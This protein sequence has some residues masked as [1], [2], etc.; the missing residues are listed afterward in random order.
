MVATTVLVII[1]V[2]VLLVSAYFDRHHLD[3]EGQRL[4]GQRVVAIKRRI[5]LSN[6]S[7]GDGPPVARLELGPHFDALRQVLERNLH[8]RAGVLLA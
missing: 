3:V 5:C 7:Y 6:S 1:E 2:S 4:A 8:D